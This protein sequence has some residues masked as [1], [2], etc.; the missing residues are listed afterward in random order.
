M[1]NYLDYINKQ[2]V[3]KAFF[4]NKMPK[5][6][7][8]DKESV[9]KWQDWAVRNGHMTQEQVNTGYGVYG[10]KTKAAYNKL[11]NQGQ[12][13]N[14]SNRQLPS[15]EQYMYNTGALGGRATSGWNSFW[16]R[17]SNAADE[18]GTAVGSFL[19]IDTELNEGAKRQF[20]ANVGNK[21]KSS[22]VHYDT[23]TRYGNASGIGSDLKNQDLTI[24]EI[25][26]RPARYTIGQNN[27]TSEEGGPGTYRH[28][29][30]SYTMN[31]PT[32]YHM[33]TIVNDDGTAQNINTEGMTREQ[34]RNIKGTVFS[35]VG[36]MIIG[37]INPITALENIA[38]RLDLKGSNR[39]GHVSANDMQEYRDEYQAFLSDPELQEKY[40]KQVGRYNLKS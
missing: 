33:I 25:V 19:G 30:G 34:R 21:H 27:Y 1:M 9:K 5:I 37:K 4:G 22:A 6:D 11:I 12:S 39:S 36:N 28:S 20:V 10:P 8:N 40:F 15:F 32:D 14:T 13:Q 29:D 17:V 23:D 2:P 38:S 3:M 35:D 18:I 31:D 7:P 24:G 26:S 16:G